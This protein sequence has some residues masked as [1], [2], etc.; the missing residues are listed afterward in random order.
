MGN[1]Y[2]GVNDQRLTAAELKLASIANLRE[3]QVQI[4]N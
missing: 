2:C 1:Y 3:D 4:T